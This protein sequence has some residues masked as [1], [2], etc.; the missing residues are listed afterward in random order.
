MTI[1]T[2]HINIDRS[3]DPGYWY[4]WSVD[5]KNTFLFLYEH[6]MN[7]LRSRTKINLDKLP[8]E[9]KLTVMFPR[10]EKITQLPCRIIAQTE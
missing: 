4:L 1:L 9:V 8:A 3:D 6:E 7:M 10:F 5:F 2:N